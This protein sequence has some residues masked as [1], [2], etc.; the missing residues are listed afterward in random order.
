MSDVVVP[1][2]E[3]EASLSK[4]SKV[5]GRVSVRTETQVDEQLAT[6]DLARD[7]VEITRVPMDIEVDTP[8]AVRTE[9]DVTIVP[10]IEERAVIRKQLVL[11]E[12]IHIRTTTSVEN[13][14]V[15][16]TTRRQAVTVER[17]GGSTTPQK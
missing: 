8:P 6:I 15:P 12:E 7:A 11:V 5:T 17:D 13:V 14:G 9:G 2:I 3:E 10:V 1:I 4:Q 16:I